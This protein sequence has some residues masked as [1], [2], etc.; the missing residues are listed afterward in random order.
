[1]RE[2]KLHYSMSLRLCFEEKAFGPG[3]SMLL[4]R[5]DETGSLQKAAQSMDMAY[6]KAWK[7]LKNAEASW[8]I[9]LAAREIG[10]RDGGGSVLTKE[11]RLL[12]EAY[13][14]FVLEGQ[15]ELDRIFSS[16]FAPE[17][18]EGLIAGQEGEEKKE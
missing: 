17:W 14:S 12:L 9:K 1:M 7:I 8:G 18:V 13:D 10:G 16:Y 2:E 15:K 3:L 4:H 6:S 11:G 5:I